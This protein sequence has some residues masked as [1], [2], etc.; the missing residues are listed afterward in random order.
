[1]IKAYSSLQGRTEW[2]RVSSAEDHGSG[3]EW[4]TV[5]IASGAIIPKSKTEK[6]SEGCCI[7]YFSVALAKYYGQENL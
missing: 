4:R 6:T 2:V 1:M 5:E 3:L 7:R